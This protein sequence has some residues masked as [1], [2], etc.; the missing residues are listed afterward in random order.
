MKKKKEE[1]EI[2]EENEKPRIVES[3]LGSIPFFGNFFKEVGKTETFKKRFE[4]VNKQIEENLRKGEKR[5][6]DFQAHISTRPIIKSPVIKEKE[7]SEVFF[8][9][10]HWYGKKRDMLAL[11]VK[12]PSQNVKMDLKNKNLKLKD[13]K[14]EKNIA[15]P[16]TYTSIR[17]KQYKKGLFFLELTK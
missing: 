16:D 11:V 15:L 7:D 6:W 17:K 14:W 9:K 3:F 10:E 8:G 5:K 13:K 4:E 12:V 1:R 2:E